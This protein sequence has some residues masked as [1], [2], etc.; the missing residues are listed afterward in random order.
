MQTLSDLTKWVGVLNRQLQ[1]GTLLQSIIADNER[2]IVDCVAN[3][4]LYE[5]G[6]NALGVYIDSYMPYSPITVE[7]KKQKGQPYDRVTLRDTGDFQKSIKVDAN[8]TEFE[9]VATDRKTP[10]LLGKYGE[11]I[12]G[13]TPENKGVLIWDKIY[14]QLLEQCKG[15][16]FGG[17]ND[18]I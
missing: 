3:K 14:P 10:A 5:Q 12:F 11:E 8:R 2:F 15:L 6:Q 9:I 1:N 4:Q 16:I 13:L 7:I 17:E 18:L